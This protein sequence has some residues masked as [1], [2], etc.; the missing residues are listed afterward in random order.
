MFVETPV[1]IC[2]DDIGLSVEVARDDGQCVRFRQAPWRFDLF[3]SGT[4][5]NAVSDR[6]ETK[7]LVVALPP[8]WFPVEGWGLEG[9]GLRARFQFA[10]AELRRLVWRLST[11]RQQGE[12]L[13]SA[14]CVAVSR[15]IVDRVVG[16]QIA[17]DARAAR[18]VGLD[19]EARRLVE[20]LVDADLQA[21]PSLAALA[22]KV[23]IDV[24]TFLR[25]FKVTHG[26][27]PRHYIQQRRLARACRLLA[28]TDASVTRIALDVG[29]SSHAHFSTVFRAAT[30][31]TPSTY[32]S[33]AS[34]QLVVQAGEG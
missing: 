23:G 8:E 10:D 18:S 5:M 15:A 31:V 22:S 4:H 2:R 17:A 7:S 3:T 13:G 27:T 21:P 33:S 34:R 24:V 6:P 16:V 12:P 1:L 9:P 26:A 30:G 32:R 11:H 28:F 19:A 20:E 14:Y 25:E 29:F